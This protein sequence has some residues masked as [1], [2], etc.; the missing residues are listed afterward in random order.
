MEQ[1]ETDL[2]VGDLNGDGSVNLADINLIIGYLLG[3]ARQR[4]PLL[5]ADC[6]GDN[7]VNIADINVLISMIINN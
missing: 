1:L 5:L 3:D 2:A 7:A 6:N 4:C